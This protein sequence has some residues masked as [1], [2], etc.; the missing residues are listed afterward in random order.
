M[1]SDAHLTHI[2]FCN[3]LPA[4]GLTAHGADNSSN[5]WHKRLLFASDGGLVITF[6]SNDGREP[7]NQSIS[8]N[9]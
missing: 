2:Q 8:S 4:C 5:V 6:Q 7:A 9:I 3:C 1:N